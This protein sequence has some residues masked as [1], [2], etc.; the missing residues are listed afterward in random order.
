MC[1]CETVHVTLNAFL[2]MPACVLKLFCSCRSQLFKLLTD[3]NILQTFFLT[4]HVFFQEVYSVQAGARWEAQDRV[5][6]GGRREQWRRG[7]FPPIGVKLRL[8]LSNHKS[9]DTGPVGLGVGGRRKQWRRGKFPPIGVKLRLFLSNHR[10]SDFDPIAGR[11]VARA[12]TK[13]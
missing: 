5:W 2:S 12:V 3:A 10:E 7:K 6:R 8:F 4:V 9:R 11:R 1:I 13:R